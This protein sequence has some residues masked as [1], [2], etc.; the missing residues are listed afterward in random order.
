MNGLLCAEKLDAEA[1]TDGCLWF[2]LL[3]PLCSLFLNDAY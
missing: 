3:F 1:C 2:E